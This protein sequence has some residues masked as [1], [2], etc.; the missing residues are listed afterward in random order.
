MSKLKVRAAMLSRI[1]VVNG[2]VTSKNGNQVG[3]W[4]FTY[5]WNNQLA[6]RQGVLR[7]TR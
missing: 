5:H 3:L 4:C 6:V 7:D 1:G 2:S